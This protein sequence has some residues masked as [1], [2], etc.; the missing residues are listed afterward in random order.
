MIIIQTCWYTG[1][2]SFKIKKIISSKPGKL[3]MC[4]TIYFSKP[5]NLTY[6]VGDG[7]GGKKFPHVQG[8]S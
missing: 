6:Q 3:V 8:L 7:F 5:F 2:C 4:M 1:S